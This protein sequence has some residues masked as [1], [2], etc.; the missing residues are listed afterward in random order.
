MNQP[1]PSLGTK[2]RLWYHAVFPILLLALGGWAAQ[3]LLN[4]GPQ[5]TKQPTAK[6][7]K[8][9]ETVALKLTDHQAAIQALGTVKAARKI[10]LMPQVSGRVEW[11]SPR[12][13]PGG[14]FQI[15]EPIL[16]LERADWAF[17]LKSA[18][19]E[20]NRVEA[21][22]QIELGRQNVARR[23]YELLGEEIDADDRDL[24]LRLPQLND[25][26]A[27]LQTAQAQLDQAQLNLE[28]CD[29]QAPFNAVV[30][31]QKVDLGSLVQ[32]NSVLASLM[33]TDRT[34]V[35][36]LVPTNQLH[37][38]TIPGPKN[39]VHIRTSADQKEP[40]L[41]TILQ[42]MSE[43]EEQG[44]MARILIEVEDP[45]ALRSHKQPLLIGSLVHVTLNGNFL[46][47]SI[48]IPREQ[49]HN[50]N[51]IWLYREGKLLIQEVKDHFSQ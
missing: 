23:E 42:L 32:T 7:A 39:G 20:L 21:E 18:Q 50:E 26:Q 41:G 43:I 24:V 47:T 17:K 37:W 10:D 11:I 1:T 49:I 28:R 30:I 14:R 13:Q 34:W 31:A 9:V 44:R 2:Q 29:V 33:G 35:E 19:A 36:V 15:G 5:A 25:I 4:S 6:R 45:M 40:V 27:K 46:P 16:Q 48:A 51:Q 22:L 8:W 12:F 38:L 3:W